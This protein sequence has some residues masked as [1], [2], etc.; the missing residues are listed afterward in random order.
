MA[1]HE[2]GWQFNCIH[3]CLICCSGTFMNSSWTHLRN[4]HECSLTIWFMNFWVH[5]CSWTSPGSWIIWVHEQPMFMNKVRVHEQNK[6]MNSWTFMKVSFIVQ[7]YS[8]TVH[9][10][11]DEPLS[12]FLFTN[13]HELFLNV[14]EQFMLISPGKEVHRSAIMQDLREKEKRKWKWPTGGH[15]GFHNC[16]ICHGLSLCE[17]LHFVLCSWA[18]YFA[19]LF[20]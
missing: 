18:R 3:E 2:L 15:F 1:V 17:T 9:E 14:H 16:E 13:I 5:G 19:F 6:L 12:F 10:H 11:V 8:W 7:E 4:V 20:S